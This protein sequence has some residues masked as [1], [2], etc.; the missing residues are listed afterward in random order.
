MLK[1]KDQ[2][3]GLFSEGF[4]KRPAEQLFDIKR[5]AA[6]THNLAGNPE[7]ASIKK[8]LKERLKKL[9]T[10]QGDPRML[11]YGDIFESYPRFGLMREWPG[12]KERGKYNPEYE[13]KGMKE[14]K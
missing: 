4:E 1:N 12:F 8:D 6:C 9:L 11:G 14:I 3:P 2:F 7:Y 13:P 10:Q 5:D